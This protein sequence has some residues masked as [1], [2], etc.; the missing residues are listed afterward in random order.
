MTAIFRYFNFNFK[1]KLKIKV[2]SF[3]FFFAKMLSN[4]PLKR[5]S[6]NKI[7][8]VLFFSKKNVIVSFYLILIIFY[9]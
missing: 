9:D 4:Y 3:V 7:R 5:K 1:L 8:D 6:Y 2:F